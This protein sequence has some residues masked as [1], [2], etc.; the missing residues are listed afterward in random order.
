MADD[1][2]GTASAPG[3]VSQPGIVFLVGLPGLEDALEAEARAAGFDGVKRVQGGV[4]I[5]GG[6]PEAARANLVLRTA[7]RVLWRVAEFRAMHLAQLDKRSR[8]VG[9]TDWLRPGVPVRVEAVCRNSK[10]YH[11]KAAAQRV[12]RAISE[13]GIPVAPEAEIVV[14]VRIED[15]LCTVSLDTTGEALHRRGHKQYVGKAP[16]RETMA[17]GFLWRMGFDGTQAVV[18]P[19]CGSGTIVLEAAEIAAALVP[20]RSRSF[21]FEKMAGSERPMVASAP[22][23]APVPRFFGYDRDAGAIRGAGE[24]AARAGVSDWCRFA[25]QPLSDLTPPEGPP[26]L[27]LANPPYGARIG[28]RKP[29][30][31]LYAALGEVLAERFP[32]WRV[33]IV[34]SDD[35]LAK[36]IGLPLVPS[37][38]IAHG[39]LKVR[40][41]QGDVPAR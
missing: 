5:A 24:N 7:V 40:L 25:C 20:G 6:L 19:M 37:A 35:G 17:A 31:G 39:G 9:W 27:V 12:A 8:K 41:W 1:A 14:K 34:T 10:I 23:T 13:A 15:D 3:P 22:A 16:L 2:P 29:L 28:S 33:G 21:A 32:G 11:D 18:D 38:P 26:G 4:E 36:T 30:F